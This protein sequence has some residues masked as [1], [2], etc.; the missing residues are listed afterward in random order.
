MNQ[1]Y[2][3][4]LYLEIH[5]ILSLYIRL[6]LIIYSVVGFRLKFC[7]KFSYPLCALQVPL[8]SWF[9]VDSR[10]T[11]SAV[12]PG[13]HEVS[14]CVLCTFAFW[15]S[16]KMYVRL[17]FQKFQ[18]VL[19]WLHW[20]PVPLWFVSWPWFQSLLCLYAVHGN[21]ILVVVLTSITLFG[22]RVDLTDCRELKSGN[23]FRSPV[24]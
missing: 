11:N 7:I 15:T 16:I 12:C 19:V 5:W 14:T 20:Y 13:V 1:L 21:R 6:G 3:V 18:N 17:R 2:R 4:T 22:Y 10:I 23:L 9:Y 24:A 8:S